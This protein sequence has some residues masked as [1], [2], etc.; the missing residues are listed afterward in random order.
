MA[1]ETE[2]PR[3]YLYRRIV[4]AKLFIEKHFADDINLDDIADE[5]YFSKFHFIKLFKFIYKE[6]PHQYLSSVRIKHAKTLLRKDI[7]AAQ[8]CYAVGF[9]S[10]STFT[11]LFKR[12]TGQ[13]PSAYRQMQ[14]EKL[15]T[16]TNYPLRFIPNC[17][18]EKNGW[19]KTDNPIG[20][21]ATT[22]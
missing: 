3:V 8:V 1:F 13:T 20:A 7:P 4:A 10:V 14:Q 16:V 5:A 19:I 18:A 17:F 15:T 22:A 11:G 9:E 6:T 12:A 21:P 2:F